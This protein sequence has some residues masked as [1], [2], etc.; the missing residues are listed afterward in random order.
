MVYFN[1]SAIRSASYD[2]NL[3]LLTITFTSGGTYIYYGVPK[4]KY[5]ELINASSAGTYFN[6][7][8]RDQ[9]STN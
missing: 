6:D 7:H 8:I 4:W 9:H 3:L 1:S 5:D 2:E